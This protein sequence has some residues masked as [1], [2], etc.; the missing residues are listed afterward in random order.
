LEAVIDNIFW[1]VGKAIL[2]VARFIGAD[3]YY[4]KNSSDPSAVAWHWL[5]VIGALLILN[6]FM[7]K[8]TEK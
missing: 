7:S 2:S 4:F 6:H 5:A 3:N 8:K 1:Y